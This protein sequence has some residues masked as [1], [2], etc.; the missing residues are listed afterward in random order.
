MPT[1]TEFFETEAR[2]ALA[3]LQREVQ[4]AAPDATIMHQ[5][6][7]ALRGA[8]QM[9]REERTLQ[10]AAALEAGLRALAGGDLAWTGETPTRVR[11]SIEDLYLLLQR[12]GDDARQDSVVEQVTSR[13][14]DVSRNPALAEH[15]AQAS[16]SIEEF[17]RFAAREAAEI[18]AALDQAV[19]QLAAAPMD[20]EPLRAV[21]RRQRALLGSARLDEAAVVAEIL[22]A[23]EDMSRV[24][25]RLD[26][27]VKQD[28]LDIYR[29]A[30]D[31]LRA[32]VEPLQRGEDPSPSHAASRLRHI[33]QEM[34]ERYGTTE[35]TPLPP[36]PDA[37]FAPQPHATAA[38]PEPAPVTPDVT[39]QETSDGVLE[40]T[41]EQIV[42]DPDTASS[43]VDIAQLQYDRDSALRRALELR[44]VIVRAAAA[45]IEANAAADELFDLIRLA[46]E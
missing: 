42:D 24:V 8:A 34:L 12:Q 29:V 27:G 9:A 5:A 1:L 3:R 13:W 30:R 15:T 41:D 26:V 35:G 18:A 20:R 2:E 40:L 19:Q 22:R 21:L 10:A 44:D 16:A 39:E 14:Q 32:A 25:A 43:T 17:R 36:Q 6:S 31:G 33:R 11:D 4:Q 38:P 45:D 23:V 37:I 28:W 7:R 46:L